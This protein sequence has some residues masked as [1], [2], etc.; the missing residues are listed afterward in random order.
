MLKNYIRLLFANW[1]FSWGGL[2][3]NR[4]GEWHLIAQLLIISAHLIPPW[5]ISNDSFL[6]LY[7]VLNKSGFLLSIAGIFLIIKAFLDLGISLTPLP[8]PKINAPLV[9][10]NSYK[11]CRHPLYQGLL[12]LSAGRSLYLLSLT[13]LILLVMLAIVLKAKAKREEFKLSILHPYYRN[14][15]KKTVAILPIISFLDWRD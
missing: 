14:Y 1:G 2:R 11:Y 5:P 3:D 7:I 12:I 9:I 6:F 10:T 8:E 4:N 13:H 15:M